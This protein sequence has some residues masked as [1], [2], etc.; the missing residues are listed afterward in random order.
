[1]ANP[2]VDFIK[3]LFTKKKEEKNKA[4]GTQQKSDTG[5]FSFID[6]VQKYEFCFHGQAFIFILGGQMEIEFDK[7]FIPLEDGSNSFFLEYAYNDVQ[8]PRKITKRLQQNGQKVLFS[9]DAI[10]GGTGIPQTELDK[11]RQTEVVPNPFRD[12][13]LYVQNQNDGQ[14][15]HLRALK[16]FLFPTDQQVRDQV[17][18]ALAMGQEIMREEVGRIF[19]TPND[20]FKGKD[21]LFEILNTCF[22]KAPGQ[23]DMDLHE[24]L[25]AFR[26]AMQQEIRESLVQSYGYVFDDNFKDWLA[27]H[28]GFRP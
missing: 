9:M 27:Q 23:A 16:G 8:G 6:S 2:F 11:L 18:P 4:R 10:F 7:Q 3:G 12:F 15:H 1:M 28:L 24:W 25:S 26:L 22:F 20:E 13:Q 19:Y 17:Q 21:A 5:G 14:K